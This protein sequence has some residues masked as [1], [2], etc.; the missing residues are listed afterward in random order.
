MVGVHREFGFDFQI[1]TDDHSPPHIHVFDAGARCI[2]VLG[3]VDEAPYIRW[4][5][6]MKPARVSRALRIVLQRQQYFL[7]RWEEIH[8]R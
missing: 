3:G 6:K 1:Y 5:K 7:E 8:G 4:V 2:I